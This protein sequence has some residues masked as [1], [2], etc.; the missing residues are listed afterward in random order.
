MPQIPQWVTLIST[1]VSVNG[2]GS[3][4]VNVSGLVASWA[5]H[6]WKVIEGDEDCEAISVVLGL[7]WQGVLKLS[8]DGR[9]REVQV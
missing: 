5:T 8:Q 6:P 2:L 4:V 9:C 1:S 3:N 7:D